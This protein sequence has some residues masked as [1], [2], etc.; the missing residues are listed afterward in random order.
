[1]DK[2]KFAFQKKLAA[3]KYAF[4]GVRL[5]L[6]YER[7]IRLHCLA[8]ICA[9]LA[10]FL[11]NISATEWLAVVVA[12]GCVFA[13]EALNTAIER[14]A[15]V[16]SPEYSEAIRKVKDLAAAGVLFVAFAAAIMGMI[17]FLPKLAAVIF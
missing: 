10:G 7:N 9:V 13:A 12:C 11:L 2:K 15:D 8:G 1:M 16:V 17:I 5:L 14:L 3:F 6:R 4:H